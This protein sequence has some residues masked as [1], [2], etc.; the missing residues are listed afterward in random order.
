MRAPPDA[1]M[2]MMGARRSM[3]RSIARVIFFADHR[4][5]AAADELQ[6]HRAD[7]HG[8]ALERPQPESSASDI[9][10]AFCIS[11]KRTEYFL[12]SEK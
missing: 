3:E 4:S 1:E 9:D 8:A 2:M 6:L 10:V 12:E 11:A 5:H 7:V